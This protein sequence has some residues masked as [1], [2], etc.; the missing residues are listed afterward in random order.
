MVRQTAALR[1]EKIMPFFKRI[2]EI[3]IASRFQY[4]R[5]LPICWSSSLNAAGIGRLERSIWHGRRR[6]IPE[7]KVLERRISSW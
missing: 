4:L 6:E 3:G 1:M 5:K 7:L 2:E